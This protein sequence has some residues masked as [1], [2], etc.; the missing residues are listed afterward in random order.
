MA[1]YQ[2]E[3]AIPQSF[4]VFRAEHSG[5]IDLPHRSM[6]PLSGQTF[7]RSTDQRCATLALVVSFTSDNEFFGFSREL[8]QKTGGRKQTESG[9]VTQGASGAKVIKTI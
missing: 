9:C 4:H 5:P 2:T 1:G 7:L 6:F 8:T 3:Q